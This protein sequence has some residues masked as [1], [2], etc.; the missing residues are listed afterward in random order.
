MALTNPHNYLGLTAFF[1]GVTATFHATVARLSGYA[2]WL[3]A[4][5]E[6]AQHAAT[7]ALTSCFRS[8]GENG[9]NSIT[10][11]TKI[12]GAISLCAVAYYLK[13][14]PPRQP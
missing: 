2:T 7:A 9:L 1:S 3:L 4:D 11:A 14:H 13:P 12:S 6:D 10:G 5:N 8:L